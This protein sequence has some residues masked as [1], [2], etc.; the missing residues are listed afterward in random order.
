M[1]SAVR[2]VLEE[3]T[4]AG[5]VTTETLQG[6]TDDEIA[7]LEQAHGVTLPAAYREFLCVMGRQAGTFF[8]GTD[9][10][11]GDLDGMREAADDLLADDEADELDAADFVFAMHQGYNFLFFRCG[12]S[13]DPPVLLYVEQE[14]GV[15][16]VANSFTAWLQG[17][18]RDEI[19]LAAEL[20]GRSTRAR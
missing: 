17:A 13:D 11:Y 18:A 1:Q 20:E 3:L 12:I 14:P 8:R 16:E 9:F 7:A 10:L 19:G 15:R 6:C 2:R 5:L 4:A